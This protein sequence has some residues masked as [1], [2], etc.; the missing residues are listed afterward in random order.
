[1][2]HRPTIAW[3]A[4]TSQGLDH[5]RCLKERLRAGEIF[6]P[7]RYGPPDRGREQTFHGPLSEQVPGLFATFDHLVFFLAAG[8]AIR[9][10]A[11]CLGS[12]TTDPG[13]I[14]IDE[15]GEFIV[16]I[17]SGHEGGAN[18][19][20]RR[21][22]GALG[23]TPVVTTGSEA[24]GGFSLPSLEDRFGWIP[25]PA[26][27]LKP[28][29][30]A[31]LDHAPVAVVQEI[32]GDRTWLDG[33]PLPEH[34]SFAGSIGDLP[35][36]PYESV[37]WITD[38]LVDDLGGIEESR[39]LW[40]RPKSLVLGVGC[41]RGISADALEEG[42]LRTIRTHGYSP[43][44]IGTLA[45]LD[46]TADEK[47]LLEL[48]NRYGW[49]TV[50][51]TAE[52][53]AGV[54]GLANPSAVVQECVGTPGVAEPAALLA[55]GA[56]RLLM[57]KQVVV[58]P[59]SPRRMTIS[60]ARRSDYQERA[61]GSCDGRVLF[62][63]AGPG[64]P[65]LLTVKADHEIRRADVI[66]YA[67]SLVPEEIVRRAPARATLHDSAHLNLEQVAAILI[68]AARAGKRVVRLQSGDLSIYSAIQEQM[69]LLDEARVP[70]D[71]IPGIS[72]YQAA[73]AALRSELTLPEV[74]QTIILT[75]GEGTTK[76][77]SAE[78][79]ASLAEHRATLCIFLS[80][81]LGEKVQEQLSAAYPPETPA[82][83]L[84]RVSWPDEKIVVTTLAQL[85]ATI[86]E[87]RLTRTTLIMVGDAIGGR[88]NRSRLYDKDHA[89]IFRR[90][91]HE[92]KDSAP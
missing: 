72:A 22:A 18:A 33:R 59:L 80:A 5:A 61:S 83:I 63:G 4:V 32:G 75:R 42:I 51:F 34:I 16:P 27:C 67:G 21:I 87:H 19:L 15:A 55:A 24:G 91:S 57:E 46:L 60:L 79:L 3:I 73:A 66:V 29:A 28:V 7:D 37:I 12:K 41:E 86:R 6:R 48:A 62:I 1:M 88:R 17:L 25:E 52:Q 78:S 74:A 85:A 49:E 14:I 44:S 20:A 69:T 56:D 77:P 8:A 84:Y 92:T 13:V 45:S 47:G 39:I 23:S 36:V 90:R 76:M 30:R 10:I 71:L 58:S 64:D 70:F 82:A 35:R 68:D 26:V 40:Q 9:L 54:P 11:P 50:F 38:R 31:L 53:L 65:D 89:H 81:R 2:S 43:T